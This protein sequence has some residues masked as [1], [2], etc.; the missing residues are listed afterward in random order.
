MGCSMRQRIQWGRL[1]RRSTAVFLATL[2]VWML[3]VCAGAGTAAGALQQL[4]EN[5]AFVS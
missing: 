3:V 4:G 2:A 5:G 1:F